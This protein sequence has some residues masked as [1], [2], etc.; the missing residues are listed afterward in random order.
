MDPELQRRYRRLFHFYDANGD[1]I[2]SVER[3]FRQVAEAV[4]ARW[5]SCKAPFPHVL[6][7][8]TRTYTLETERRDLNHNGVVDEQEFV[9]SH[10]PAVSAF[11]RLRDQ[12]EVFI[13][14]SA[15]GFF[16]CLD[17]DGDGVLDVADLEAYASAYGKPTAGIRAN[18]AR[19]LAAFGL[20]PDRLPKQVF[21]TLVSQYWFDPSPDVP[22]RWLFD[23]DTKDNP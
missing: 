15:G 2:L 14:K 11:T 1:G 18:L 4:A 17:L 3:D 16:D 20:P 12:A 13:A 10:A 9:A 21:L 7:L 22:G 5:K 8:L 19:M 23:L 6:D